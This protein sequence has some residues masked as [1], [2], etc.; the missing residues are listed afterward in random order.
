MNSNDDSIVVFD[1]DDEQTN[2]SKNY[3]WSDKTKN[4]SNNL[5]QETDDER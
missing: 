3:S 1:S 2:V 5:I 4:L